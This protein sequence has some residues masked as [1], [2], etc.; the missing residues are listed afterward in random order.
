MRMRK[1]VRVKK[2]VTH[3]TIRI[4]IQKHQTMKKTKTKGIRGM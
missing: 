1:T 2:E 3:S 4:S